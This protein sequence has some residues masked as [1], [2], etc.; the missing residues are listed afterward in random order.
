MIGIG[1][2]EIIVVLIVIC[3]LTIPFSIVAIIDILRSNFRGNDKIVWLLV[4]IFL[5]IP[6]IILYGVIGK[7]QKVKS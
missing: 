7:K 6:G 3:I 2:Y 1:I 5:S 4:V